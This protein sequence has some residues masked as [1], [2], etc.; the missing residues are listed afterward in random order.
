MTP[1]KKR[2]IPIT[3]KELIEKKSRNLNINTKEKL[4]P[5]GMA[6]LLINLSWN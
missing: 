6:F 2:C 4:F 3:S 1:P 5:E